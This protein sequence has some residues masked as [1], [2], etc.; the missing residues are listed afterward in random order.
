MNTISIF[1]NGELH[2]IP[3]TD[4]AT[5]IFA[6]MQDYFDEKEI[7]LS[8]RGTSRL[9]GDDSEVQ[10][11]SASSF[12][13]RNR[14]NGTKV[15]TVGVYRRETDDNNQYMIP[16]DLNEIILN[17]IFIDFN[18]PSKN[19]TDNLSNA[20][21]P[22]EWTDLYDVIPQT[23]NIGT[24]DTSTSATIN[25]EILVPVES[26]SNI[27]PTMSSV[28]VSFKVNADGFV[29]FETTNFNR[30]KMVGIDDSLRF[31]G[32]TNGSF[33]FDQALGVSSESIGVSGYF[34]AGYEF[35][36]AIT[37]NEG[38][39]ITEDLT[40]YIK[41]IVKQWYEYITYY[42][43]TGTN[44]NYG[45]NYYE[46]SPEIGTG[47]PTRGMRYQVIYDV[48]NVAKR[49][50]YRV[51]QN[52]PAI[53]Q[54]RSASIPAESIGQ[55][56]VAQGIPSD[57]TFT[58]AQPM[59]DNNYYAVFA[60]A[61]EYPIICT[62][63]TRSANITVTL[64]ET[65]TLS[66]DGDV[67]MYG[68]GAYYE[69]ITNRLVR[70]DRTVT[71]PNQVSRKCFLHNWDITTSLTTMAIT[72]T[73]DLTNVSIEL[74]PRYKSTTTD[75]LS[76]MVYRAKDVVDS[77]ENGGNPN[78]VVEIGSP[79]HN[80][81]I[82]MALQGDTSYVV[83]VNYPSSNIRK[84]IYQASMVIDDPKW[85]TKRTVLE[86]PNTITEPVHVSVTSTETTIDEESENWSNSVAG[87]KYIRLEGGKIYSFTANNLTLNVLQKYDEG[88][89]S[90][91]LDTHETIAGLYGT[92]YEND[93]YEVPAGKCM[94][95][96]ITQRSIAGGTLAIT[97]N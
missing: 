87:S 77:F 96:K 21:P 10:L 88:N 4:G 72:P 62:A 69:P 1:I 81:I 6:A 2:D 86:V 20:T 54:L 76:V 33:L 41:V 61:G 19:T 43:N 40:T 29:A 30:G 56:Y 25:K 82:N 52:Y 48:N 83:V 14:A 84:E 32:L 90:A 11:L 71:D 26:K 22:S 34:K 74:V 67:A 79:K 9:G 17:N 18:D 91:F 60:S 59:D 55:N 46:S 97:P 65:G 42:R 5:T 64:Y 57:T 8:I 23:V 50:L 68:T 95:I 24:I 45:V 3:I 85:W 44:L 38:N 70:A 58:E 12:I 13:K 94:L 31:I 28:R 93:L 73:E 27:N 66:P 15:N 7:N 16:D 39:V 37:V 92:L 51:S 80:E 89:M 53:S 49:R 75:P 47:I 78:A 63:S 35:F 36:F